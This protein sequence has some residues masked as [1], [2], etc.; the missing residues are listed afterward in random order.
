MLGVGVLFLIQAVMAQE[1]S[2]TESYWVFR[3]ATN[4]MGYASII[5]PAIFLKRYL[6]SRN[7]K[8]ES[9]LSAAALKTWIKTAVPDSG[10]RILS[11]SSTAKIFTTLNK[12]LRTPCLLH[13][14]HK[15]QLFKS[16][17]N[18]ASALAVFMF[19]FFCQNYS[20]LHILVF[21]FNLGCASRANYYTKVWC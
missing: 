17:S 4:M 3:L 12:A 6:D 16:L 9:S 2:S 8:G 5:V 21:I 1:D 10:T 15:W 14:S 11:I 18:F 7:Y 20:N 13:R 19:V